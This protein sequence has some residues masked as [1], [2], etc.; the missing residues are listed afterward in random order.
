M[1]IGLAFLMM[2]LRAATG[3]AA[4]SAYWTEWTGPVRL[5]RVSAQAVDTGPAAVAANQADGPAAA[6][7][8]ERGLRGRVVNNSAHVHSALDEHRE[9]MY[10]PEASPVP[11]DPERIVPMTPELWTDEQILADFRK[12]RTPEQE[13]LII[14]LKT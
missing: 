5:P 13:G 10:Y 4:E 12:N 8:L 14:F 9:H 2:G 3:A 1:R 7:A 11:M 6:L